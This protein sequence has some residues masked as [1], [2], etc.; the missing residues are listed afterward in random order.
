ML[1]HFAAAALISMSL[2]ELGLYLAECHKRQIPVGVLH[3][4]FLALLFVLG[5]AALVRARAIAR[6]VD[7]KL[8]E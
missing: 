7:T 4:S 1:V 6:W 2:L 3:A 8:D 5:V